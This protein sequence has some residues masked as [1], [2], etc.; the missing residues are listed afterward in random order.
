MSA[1]T[2]DKLSA[3]AEEIKAEGGEAVVVVGDVSKVKTL[4]G[5]TAGYSSSYTH[6]TY[7]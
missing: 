7:S 3:V 1:R 2:E 6:S 5:V 4:N